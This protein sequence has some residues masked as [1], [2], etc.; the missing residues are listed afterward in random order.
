[1]KAEAEAEAEV[2]EE[3]EEEEAEVEV[4]MEMRMRMRKP[5]EG[6]QAKGP[7]SRLTN[8]DELSWTDYS[9]SSGSRCSSHSSLA[10]SLA[11]TPPPR[12]SSLR[13]EEQQQQQESP[14][15]VVCPQTDTRAPPQWSAGW[16]EASGLREA[17]NRPPS[18]S[19][20]CKS[21]DNNNDG[22]T[23]DT[24]GQGT[25]VGLASVPHA[26]LRFSPSSCRSKLLEQQQQWLQQRLG[27]HSSSDRQ[28]A[29]EGRQKEADFSPPVCR[30]STTTAGCQLRDEQQKEEQEEEAQRQTGKTKV[31]FFGHPSPGGQFSDRLRQSGNN[32][33]SSCCAGTEKWPTDDTLCPASSLSCSNG[34]SCCLKRAPPKMTTACCW[35]ARPNMES[36][37]GSGYDFDNGGRR[38]GEPNEVEMEQKEEKGDANQLV[39]NIWQEN[40][41]QPCGPTTVCGP[42][43]VCSDWQ[44]TAASTAPAATGGPQQQS[45][46]S[47]PQQITAGATLLGAGPIGWATASAKQE[48]SQ[49]PVVRQDACA[50]GPQASEMG[51]QVA[52][53]L[54]VGTRRNPAANL[55]E[56]GPSSAR[57]QSITKAIQRQ[58]QLRRQ[59]LQKQHQQQQQEQQQIPLA[60]QL[61]PGRQFGQP[62]TH[63]SVI[64]LAQPPLASEFR[65]P[66]QPAGHQQTLPAQ[67]GKVLLAPPLPAARQSM[68]QQ[69]QQQ[70][71]VAGGAKSSK[72]CAAANKLAAAGPELWAGVQPKV[73]PARCS[74]ANRSQLNSISSTSL[75]SI[76]ST[77][78][79][80][81]SNSSQ[82]SLAAT[83]QPC[84]HLTLAR[85]PQIGP[86]PSRPPPSVPTGQ[87]VA[88]RPGRQTSGAQQDSNRPTGPTNPSSNCAKQQAD[89]KGS[90]SKKVS[91]F[92]RLSFEWNDSTRMIQF[93]HLALPVCNKLHLVAGGVCLPRSFT[94]RIIDGAA[95]RAEFCL[96]PRLHFCALLAHAASQSCTLGPLCGLF[97]VENFGA[98][99]KVIQ[100]QAVVRKS[101]TGVWTRDWQF[102]LH[103]VRTLERSN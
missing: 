93:E 7:T 25:Q 65:S 47:R 6:E 14:G 23:L 30:Q 54:A 22:R 2:E 52:A 74:P 80:Q 89:V 72:F 58:E 81:S 3:E 39:G 85:V 16:R 87:Q 4:E 40:M 33:C 24:N 38:I 88:G 59:Q 71:L 12:L 86:P 43:V 90:S 69:Q 56:L 41:R 62:P 5:V 49:A 94:L 60:S 9:V 28:L 18:I 48:D 27:Q 64:L 34:N 53:A 103:L 91:F 76:A 13:Q 78:S 44:S 10:S 11:P 55:D 73:Q 84:G 1:M 66:I 29:A 36:I 31:G 61:L 79:S 67:V 63:S 19:E 46:H 98:Q 101:W 35:N 70:L 45:G 68:F 32:C 92:I 42:P 75:S 21:G 95:A 8:E 15:Q 20:G 82:G 99:S 26:K 97:W 83:R 37:M 100:C 17:K 50:A 102:R 96:W 51:G 77:L 57:Q